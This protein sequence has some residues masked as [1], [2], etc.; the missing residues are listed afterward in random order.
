MKTQSPLKENVI[1]LSPK[2]SPQGG[3]LTTNFMLMTLPRK[4]GDDRD[5]F[6]VSNL[7]LL[8][9]HD[10]KAEVIDMKK[11]KQGKKKYGSFY[12]KRILLCMI[13]ILA[14]AGIQLKQTWDDLDT[15]LQTPTEW[16][17]WHDEDDISGKMEKAEALDDLPLRLAMLANCRWRDFAPEG[18]AGIMLFHPQK[19][20]YYFG[21]PIGFAAVRLNGHW[22]RYYLTD[23]AL[24]DRLADSC[25]FYASYHSVV[26]CRD[27][28]FCG[29]SAAAHAS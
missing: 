15:E 19:E 8:T 5:C 10:L 9:S 16:T 29:D 24:I 26:V 12:L 7:K 3:S 23:Q 18:E 6:R 17:E 28:R 11:R 27:L 2:P 25:G 13:A 14:I 1:N 20:E 22:N 4:A 21:D